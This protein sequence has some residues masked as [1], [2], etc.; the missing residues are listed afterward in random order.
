MKWIAAVGPALLLVTTV[1]SQ[2]SETP[3]PPG[4]K[5]A[6]TDRQSSHIGLDSVV[7]PVPADP[8]SALRRTRTHIEDQLSGDDLDAFEDALDSLNSIAEQKS[9]FRKVCQHYHIDPC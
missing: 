1:F 4:D 2:D 7:S 3:S 5:P 9:F 8:T 6:Q